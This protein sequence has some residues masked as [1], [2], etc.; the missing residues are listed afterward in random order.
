MDKNVKTI[1]QW[2]YQNRNK[3]L[4]AK[5]VISGT[6]LP[7]DPFMF[8]WLIKNDLVTEVTSNFG[9]K[10]YRISLGGMTKLAENKRRNF[11]EY[12]TLVISLIAVAVSIAA[13]FRP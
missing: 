7:I 3:W 12:T 5:D 1:L 11:I 8:E 10:L 2:F 6:K 4:P 13:F 9:Q